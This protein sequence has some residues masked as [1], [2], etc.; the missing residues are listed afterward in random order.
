MSEAQSQAQPTAPR[1]GGGWQFALF[2]YR[3]IVAPWPFFVVLL[4][5]IGAVGALTPLVEIKAMSGLIN[6]LTSHAAAAQSTN[7]RSL[8][9][10][11]APYL[12]WV[13]LLVGIRIV[14]WTIYMESFQRYLAARLNERVRLALEP[15]FFRH[16]LAL[17]LEVFEQPAFYDTLQRAARSMDE[18]AVATHLTHLQRLVSLALGSLAILWALGRV[19]WLI[20]LALCGGSI[21]LVAWHVRREREFIEINFSQTPLARR[22]DYW[23]ALL[24]RRA[25]AAEVRLFGLADHIARAWHALTERALQEISAARHRNVRSAFPVMAANVLLFGGV[26]LALI[27]QAARGRVSAGV[28]VALLYVTE[29]YLTRLHMISW[30]VETLQRFFAELRYV[31]RFFALAAERVAAGAH[32]P[33]ALRVG[34]KFDGVGFTYPGSDGRPALTDVNLHIRPG[35]RIALVGENGAGKSTLA[36]LLLGLYQPTTGAI[37]VD[38]CDLQTVAPQAWRAQ[39]GAVLQDFMRYDLTVRENIGFGQTARLDDLPAIAAAAQLS[40]AVELIE[41]LPARYETVLGK[42]FA[43]G[44]DLST[45]QW[46]KLALARVY[47]RDPMVLVL[48]EP[49]AALDAHAE[50]EIYRRFLQLSAGKTVLLIS[51]RLGSA[52]LADRI[53]FLQHGRIVQAGTHDELIAAGGPYAELYELQ[54]QWYRDTETHG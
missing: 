32:T 33:A 30:R 53:L 1:M 11:L 5:L 6:A 27:A 44:Q 18:A 34:I 10:A 31:P 15:R 42:Q 37:T 41:H 12:L 9:G 14:S 20:P 25:P 26:S 7:A 48:D 45:G 52:R 46:Q 49:A 40:S 39:T 21:L 29:S 2:A 16:A 3:T 47:L 38:G 8:F 50:R 28:L 13:A 36:K 24:T 4:A 51:H 54:A 19:H 22:R 43:G 17:R 35:E 23:R